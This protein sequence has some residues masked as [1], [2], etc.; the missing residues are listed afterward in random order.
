MG[1]FTDAAAD[2]E[3]CIALDPSFVKGYYRLAN[4]QFELEKYDEAIATIR[5]GLQK[6]PTMSELT[7]LLRK[8]KQRKGGKGGGQRRPEMD[9]ATRKEVGVLAGCA[10]TLPILP[11]LP[12]H[13]LKNGPCE[14][15]PPSS[16]WCVSL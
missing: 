7:K 4:A 13:P 5:S 6:D 8:I 15:I 12:H 14:P 2:A 11:T 16:W 10:S 1:N 3:K 9:E